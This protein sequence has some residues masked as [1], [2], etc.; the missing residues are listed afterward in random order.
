[1]MSLTIYSDRHRPPEGVNIITQ[2]DVYFN[3]AVE[4]TG[5][6]LEAVIL[7]HIDRARYCSNR[8]FYGISSD[9]VPVD[10]NQ[11]STGTKTLLNVLSS[12]ALCFDLR[13]CGDNALELL[14]LITSGTVYWN[15]PFIAYVGDANCDILYNGRHYTDFY[16]FLGTVNEGRCDG[17][18][19]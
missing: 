16:A 13:E 8:S 9:T 10:K 4:L 6:K 2:N 12:P 15:I 17:D 5:S 18:E 14:P 11:L 1:M 19:D 3:G 7:H